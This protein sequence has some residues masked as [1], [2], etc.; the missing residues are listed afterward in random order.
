MR[1]RQ[2]RA[3]WFWGPVAVSIIF[4]LASA[5]H[6]FYAPWDSAVLGFLFYQLHLGA[7][8]NLGATWSG[9][10][11]M[12]AAAHAFD[13]YARHAGRDWD[14]ARGWAC[15]ALVLLALS[16]DEI[17]SIHERVL[18]FGSWPGTLPFAVILGGM[19][20]YG[21]V[22]LARSAERAKVPY[23]LLGFFLLS[24]VPLHEVVEH[25][26]IESMTPGAKALRLVLEEGT[27]LCGLLILFNVVAG[28]T[29]RLS[30]TG[31]RDVGT[32]FEAVRRLRWVLAGLALALA[33][34]LAYLTV[35]F[36]DN[37]GR[38]AN[39]AAGLLFA[40]AALAAFRAYLVNR[41]EMGWHRW[42][43]CAVCGLAFAAVANISPGRSVGIGPLD[44]NLAPF[45][46]G[47]IVLLVCA[48]S[49]SHTRLDIGR[50]GRI[51]AAVSALF[52]GVL[53]LASMSVPLSSL[54][55]YLLSQLGAVATFVVVTA[56]TETQTA[57]LP[58]TFKTARRSSG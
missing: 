16:A 1:Q 8:N 13:G 21:L 43:L 10:L 48:I 30:S 9:V 52:G 54:V 19:V 11:P 27:E 24:T 5:L 49:L 55:V 2:L 44:V 35:A 58:Y 50:S 18:E 32:A 4:L 53:L 22:L 25:R 57:W 33:P 42:A 38:L 41:A 46:V 3:I 56:N 37:Q 29:A 15:I 28:N 12:L 17:G 26:T 7:E 36:E 6:R 45:V 20:G 40:A 39:W 51:A 47:T 31:G 34:L 23:L 14:L